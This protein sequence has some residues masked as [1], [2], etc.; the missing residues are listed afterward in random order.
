MSYGTP[1][2][3]DRIEAYYT[4]I[5]RGSPPPAELLQELRDRY[6]AIGGLFPLRDNTNKQVQALEDELNRRAREEGGGLSYACFQGLKHASPFI[7]DGVR[8]M[9][10]DGIRRGVGVVLAPH[11]SAMSVGGYI[12]R[13]KETA[14]SVQG[15]ELSCVRSYHLHPQLIEALAERVES[16]LQRFPEEE[17]AS[18]RVIFSAHSLPTKIL[19]MGDPYPDQLLETSRDVAER[20]GVVQ[21]QFGWQSAGRTQTPWL[22]PDILELLRTLRREEDVRNVLICP[23]GFVSDHLEVL[24]DIDIEGQAVAKELGVHLERTASLNVDPLYIA[25]LADVVREQLK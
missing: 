25:V 9:A 19:E 7:E 5:R 23:L 1:E 16:A 6:E 12:Q 2:S 4:H 17:R 21:W 24:Y 8:A 13:A 18:V 14:A 3:M 11:Y 15:L 10:A 22:G 20:S